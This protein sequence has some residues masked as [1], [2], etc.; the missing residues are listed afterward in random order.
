MKRASFPEPSRRPLPSSSSR[1]R[2]KNTV[3]YVE[4]VPI[5][6]TYSSP[7]AYRASFHIALFERGLLL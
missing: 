4:N 5:P 3:A 1:P 2:G 6:R 7:T